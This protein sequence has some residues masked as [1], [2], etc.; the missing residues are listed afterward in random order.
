[1]SPTLGVAALPLF[2][3]TNVT[4]KVYYRPLGRTPNHHHY[5]FLRFLSMHIFERYT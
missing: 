1:M 4:E 3:W 5:S 2:V